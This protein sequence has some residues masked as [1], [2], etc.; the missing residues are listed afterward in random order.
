M[1]SA[2]AA[3]CLAAAPPA[4]VAL[5]PLPD[6]A[7]ELN[8]AA[9]VAR[10]NA[11]E[12]S[13]AAKYN[14]AAEALDNAVAT[15]TSKLAPYADSDTKDLKSSAA[16]DKRLADKYRT[17]GLLA[18]QAGTDKQSAWLLLQSLVEGDYSVEHTTIAD[19]RVQELLEQL[20]KLDPGAK[21]L[22]APRKVKVVIESPIKDTL[23]ATYAEDLVAQLRLLGLAASTVDGDEELRVV[24]SEGKELDASEVTHGQ[25]PMVSCEV[26]SSATWRAGGRIEMEHLDFGKRG[27]GFSDIPDNCLKAQLKTS[28][29]RAPMS[30]LRN[31][32]AR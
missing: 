2:L 22:F 5:R 26:V 3:L 28:A 27:A 8:E 18:V 21:A 24:A 12:L 20:R 23:K 15:A 4:Q 17:R 19:P 10:K 16:N 31:W 29:A 30:I 14:E 25:T 11:T 1:I 6:V 32:A 9:K 13:K 7:R